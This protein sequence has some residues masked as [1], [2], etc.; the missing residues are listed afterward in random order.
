MGKGYYLL[1][2]LDCKMLN[3]AK[4]SIVG[5]AILDFLSVFRLKITSYF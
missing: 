5:C 2:I 3:N 1:I 4:F